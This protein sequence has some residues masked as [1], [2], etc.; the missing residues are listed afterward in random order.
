MASPE[1]RPALHH[2]HQEQAAWKEHS[3][4]LGSVSIFLSDGEGRLLMVQDLDEHGGKWSP[5]A[6]YIDDIDHEE[7][8]AAALREAKEEL[9]LDVRLKELLG[10][11]HYYTTGDTENDGKPHMHVGYAYTGTIVGG[12]YEKQAEEIQNFGFF[13]PTQVEN[14]YHEGKLKTPQYNYVGFKLWESGQRHPLNVI[15]T[16]SNGHSHEHSHDHQH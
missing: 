4:G 14:M 12:T 8:E 16:N 2:T 7:P 11:W 3:T 13:T 6:G 1:Q 15:Q 10:V 9:G 5:I